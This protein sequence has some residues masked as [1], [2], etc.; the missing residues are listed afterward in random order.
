MS[1]T[2]VISARTLIRVLEKLGFRQT[3]SRGSHRRFEH[4]DGRKTTVPVHRGRDLPRGLLW[5]IVT[6]DLE[7]TMDEFTALL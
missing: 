3:R 1:E 5:Q 6:I 4:P 7:M 2:P